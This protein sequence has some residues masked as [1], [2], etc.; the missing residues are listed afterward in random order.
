MILDKLYYIKTN[1]NFRTPGTDPLQSVGFKTSFYPM[2]IML[3]T[4]IE[5]SSKL[6][7]PKKVKSINNTT[8]PNLVSCHAIPRPVTMKG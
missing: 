8:S 2:N 4:F 3:K 6:K 5:D 1:I 7:Q